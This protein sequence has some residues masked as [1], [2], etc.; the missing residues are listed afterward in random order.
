MIIINIHSLPKINLF[1][2]GAF[3]V[4]HA[5]RAL[6]NQDLSGKGINFGSHTYIFDHT[7]TWHEHETRYTPFTHPFILTRSIWKDDYDGQMIFGDLLGLKLPD[8]Y[9]TG[10]ENPPKNLTQ[11]TC[12]DRRSNPGPLWDRRAFYH[13][14]HSG[15]LL[16]FINHI[17]KSVK[18]KETSITQQQKYTQKSRVGSGGKSAE[19]VS[20]SII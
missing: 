1:L 5:T 19:L 9:L 6:Q 13:L 11:E 18:L 15:G 17:I 12:P 14:F 7:R 2:I 3:Y 4:T 16:K 20:Y 8:I 10:E